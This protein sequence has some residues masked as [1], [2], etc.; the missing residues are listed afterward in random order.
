MVHSSPKAEVSWFKNGSPVDSNSLASISQR[1][2]RHVLLI[3]SVR[4]ESFGEYTCQA[5]NEFGQDQKTTTVSG[6]IGR[7]ENPL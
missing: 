6:R 1:G 5:H 3:Q 7:T 2:N 4:E